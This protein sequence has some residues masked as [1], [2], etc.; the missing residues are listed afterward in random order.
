MGPQPWLH[1]RL[2]V[3]GA[4][5]AAFAFLLIFRNAIYPNPGTQLPLKIAESSDYAAMARGEAAQVES[6]F[7]KRFLFRGWPGHSR[8]AG[9]L[10]ER[11]AF[12]VLDAVSLALL[13]DASP[14][15]W[16]RPGSRP[17]SPPPC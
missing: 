15:S 6:P 17:G 13:A 1:S 4:I 9:G 7:T 10:N 14:R 16:R 3:S 11:T 2:F 5:L 8:A 12:L